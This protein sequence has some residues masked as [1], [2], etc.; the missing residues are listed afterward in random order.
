MNRPTTDIMPP[1]ELGSAP[2]A[3]PGLAELIP[4]GPSFLRRLQVV[5][6]SL[7]L[8][9][10]T[11]FLLERFRAILQPLFI[12]VFIAYVT[13]PIHTWLVERRV[14]SL[15]AYALILV[16]LLLMLVGVGT[17]AF[18]N[19]REVSTRL[20]A[21]EQRLETIVR[22][23][24]A[25]LPIELPHEGRLLRDLP[26]SQYVSAQQLM[27]ALGTAA[28]TFFDFFVWLAVTFLYLIFLILEKET[29]PQRIRR[30]FGEEQGERIF[31]IVASMNLAIA[32]Y[33][34]VKTLVSLL[35]GLTS[36][37]VMLVFDVDFAFTFALLIFLFNFIPYLGSMV[38]TGLPILL[39]FV[40]LGL[41]QFVA[42]T[43]LL[44]AVQLIVGVIFEPR[45]A[46]QR[47][48]VSPLLILLSLAFWGVLWGIVG[49]ILAVP[50]LVIIKIILDNIKETRP[51]ATLISNV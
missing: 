13:L 31:G 3:E 5:T 37:V 6:L 44:I 40:Q 1:P 21:Y 28:G 36:L 41:W 47:L 19:G 4:E 29:F 18:V 34:S 15:A 11:V 7:L 25:N 39:S 43:V 16:L 23:A 38:A 20:P 8:L 22:D 42:V 49:M 35:A 33:I 2:R 27:T 51:L 17:L 24:I 26:L 46:G 30:A 14:P 50:M 12:G 45:I 48:S 32:H 9:V 10:L